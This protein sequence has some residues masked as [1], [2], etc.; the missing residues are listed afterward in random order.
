MIQEKLFDWWALVIV[1]GIVHGLVVAFALF[2]NKR[3]RPAG[4]MLALLVLILIWH[5][6]Q[7]LSIYLGFYKTFPHFYGADLGSLF[8]VGPLFYFYIRS[9]T[10]AEGLGIKNQDWLHIIPFVIT[11]ILHPVLFQGSVQKVETIQAWLTATRYDNPAL[12][13]A[14]LLDDVIFWLE[15][16]HM[17]AYLGFSLFTLK[18]YGKIRKQYESKAHESNYQWLIYLTVAM[19]IVVAVS[20]IL[21]KSLYLA[22]NYYY[23]SL[24]YIYIIPMTIVIYSIG[25]FAI[26][27]PVVFTHDLDFKMRV[28]KY[29]RSS[30]SQEQSAAYAR[31]VQAYMQSEKPY[32]NSELKLL[33]LAEAVGLK[34]NHLSQVIN[35][36]FGKSFF[37]FINS[38]RIEEARRILNDPDRDKEKLLGVALDCGFNNKVS[39][40]NYFKKL[41]GLTPKAYREN[42]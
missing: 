22:L 24:D 26:R 15:S 6:L 35:E 42:R 41:T 2:L 13:R 40:N 25:F 33:E 9:V 14:F 21:Q 18:G 31:K 8:L 4:S 7:S 20:F 19:M 39:F 12:K 38:Y 1:L 11:V 34:S 17:L 27:R 36:Q 16:A 32:L 5:H 23:Y 3:G 29:A 37:D 10:S 30:M 28:T